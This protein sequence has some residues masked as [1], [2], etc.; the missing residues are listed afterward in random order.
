M[1]IR[2][3][4]HIAQLLGQIHV[5]EKEVERLEKEGRR[6]RADEMRA[7]IKSAK[8]LVEKLEGLI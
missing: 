6:H 3:T 4:N 8:R 7:W 5:W 1:Q 2:R